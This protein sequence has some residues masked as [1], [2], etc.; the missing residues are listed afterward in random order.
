[1][2]VVGETEWIRGLEKNLPK[3]DQLF[4]MIVDKLGVFKL[5]EIISAVCVYHPNEKILYFVRKATE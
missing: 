3:K 1:M 4:E 2:A 5:G